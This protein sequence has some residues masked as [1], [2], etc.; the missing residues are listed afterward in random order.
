MAFFEVTSRELR[1]KAENLRGL[2]G[3][4]RAKCNE[5]DSQEQELCSM[6]DG[7]AKEAFLHAFAR[8]KE[9][10]LLFEKLI[11]RYVEVMLEIAVRY[12]EAEARNAEIAASRSY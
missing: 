2:N 10:M 1:N 3:Q 9:Q 8:D 6:W 7:Q 4:F 11:E 12:E 5:L